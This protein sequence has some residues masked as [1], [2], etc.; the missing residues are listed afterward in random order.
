MASRG[1]ARPGA[2]RKP[3]SNSYG[4]STVPVRIP[5]SQVPTIQH[6]LETLKRPMNSPSLHLPDPKAP[7]QSWPLFQARI[8]AGFPSPADD[9]LDDAIDLNT[10]LV[11]HPA[12]TFFLRVQGESMTGA[13]IQDGDLVIVDRAEE[14]RA[15]SVVVA[16]LDGE[17][18]LKFLQRD[19]STQHVWLESAHPDYPP[20]AITAETDLV[21]WGVVTHVV[22][23]F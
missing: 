8:P 6:W 7:P 14:P 20:R 15:G 21:I 23:A 22:H 2:G 12:A 1:G 11:R 18:T 16:A 17:L 13:G 9:D 5:R 10:H 19:S 3:G 4:E